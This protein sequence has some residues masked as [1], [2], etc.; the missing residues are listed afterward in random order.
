MASHPRDARVSFDVERHRYRVDGSTPMAWTSVTQ[1]KT[2]LLGSGGF[3]AH[4]A[5][6]SVLKGQHR[7]PK[8]KYQGK[9]RE[10]IEACWEDKRRLGT[11]LHAQIEARLRGEPFNPTSRVLREAQLWEAHWRCPKPLLRAEWVVFSEPWGL[12]GTLDALFGAPDDAWLVDWKRVDGRWMTGRYDEE[13]PKWG[14]GDVSGYALQT[15]LY[16][17]ILERHYDVR[18]TRMMLVQINPSAGDV[19][20]IEVPRSGER[21][22][23]ALRVREAD[24]RLG[25]EVREACARLQ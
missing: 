19:R 9:T 12:A 24:L 10:E 8:G 14:T 2:L 7:A 25:A 13:H 17:M 21:L 5:L 23:G 15:N 3:S 4:L 20:T 18:V 22:A 1:L 6:A 16:R 11:E